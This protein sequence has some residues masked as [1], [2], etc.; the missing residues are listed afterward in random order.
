MA[1]CQERAAMMMFALRMLIEKYS[2][3]QVELH[4][5]FVDL[6]NT[7]DKVLRE[8]EWHFMRKSGITDKY[9]RL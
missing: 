7:Y 6:Q 8:E 5:V 9:V 2:E 1:S 3:G 4:C